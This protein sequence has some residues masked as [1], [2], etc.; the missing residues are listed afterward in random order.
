M[1]AKALVETERRVEALREELN[2]LLRSG[3]KVFQTPPV[4]WIEERLEQLGEVLERRSGESAMVLRGLLGPIRLVPTK[5]N[6]GR[7]YYVA[8]TS[9]DALA[10]LDASKESNRR[11]GGSNSLRWWRRW[12]SNPRPRNFSRRLLRV[13]LAV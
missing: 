3:E 4:E 7:P 9:I 6:I 5:G 12:E 13:Q 10:V 1:L 11:D 2:G 8:Q